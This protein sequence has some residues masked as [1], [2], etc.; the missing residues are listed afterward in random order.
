MGF[1]SPILGAWLKRHHAFL[2]L[3]FVWVYAAFWATMPLVGW[4]NYA[5]EPFGTSCTLDWWLAQASVSGQSFVMAILFFCLILPAGM[6]VF[7]YVMIIFKVKS[8]AKEI[9]H[10][11]ARIKNSHTLEMKL[12]KVGPTLM[13]MEVE[14]RAKIFE[15]Y[16]VQIYDQ[17]IILC[18][19]GNGDLHRLLDSL[20]PLCSGVSGVSIW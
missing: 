17:N 2:C 7:S 16:S 6:I 11:D 19:G 1:L 10:Y 8:S 14:Q 18:P 3:A 12:T 20:D 15:C 4:G 9:S 13:I 5:P